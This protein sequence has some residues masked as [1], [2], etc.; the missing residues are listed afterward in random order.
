MRIAMRFTLVPKARLGQGFGL[1]GARRI[2]SE[3][4]YL[5]PLVHSTL[6]SEN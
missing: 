4:S 2:Q 5:D 6:H 1:T 3:C